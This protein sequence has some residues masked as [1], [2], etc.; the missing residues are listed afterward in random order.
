LGVGDDGLVLLLLE[1]RLERA[2]EAGDGALEILHI[3]LLGV[4]NL[5][6]NKTTM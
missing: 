1:E 2:L 3:G 5:A 6:R 4:A